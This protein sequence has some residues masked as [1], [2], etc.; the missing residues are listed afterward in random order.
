MSELP[1]AVLVGEM[2]GHITAI[3]L[4]ADAEPVLGWVT[5]GGRLK[6]A[7]RRRHCV[8]AAKRERSIVYGEDFGR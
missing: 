3:L 8:R 2:K 4:G 7:A 1:C 5:V 6:S